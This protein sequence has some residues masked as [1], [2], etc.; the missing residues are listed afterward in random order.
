MWLI[1]KGTHFL[2]D[3]LFLKKQIDMIDITLN[4]DQRKVQKIDIKIE[5]KKKD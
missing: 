2:I 4:F 1:L 5:T 3:W